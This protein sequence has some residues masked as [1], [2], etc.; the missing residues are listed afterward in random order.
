[1]KTCNETNCKTSAHCK[2]LCQYHYWESRARINRTRKQVKVFEGETRSKRASKPVKIYR[3]PKFSKKHLKKL[4]EYRP[5]RDKYMS[6]HPNCEY[7]GCS[8]ESQDLHHCKPRDLHL[9]DVSIF[10]AVCRLH[11]NWIHANPKESRK[12]GYL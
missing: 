11:H 6:E 9:C 12:L 5:L 1:M 2:G 7:V 8:S 4:S 10:L 3:I